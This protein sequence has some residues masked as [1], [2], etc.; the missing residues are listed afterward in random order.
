VRS[1]E[2]YLQWVPSAP[3]ALTVARSLLARSTQALRGTVTCNLSGLGVLAERYVTLQ[4][5]ELPDLTDTIVEITAS[6][7]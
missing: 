2:L 5:S 6:R 7:P 3:Q 4:I 1:N